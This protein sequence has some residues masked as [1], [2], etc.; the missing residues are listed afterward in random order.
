[1]AV[2]IARLFWSSGEFAGHSRKRLNAYN[3]WMILFV[4]I[5]SLC[6][7]YTANVIS[8]TLGEHLENLCSK[9]ATILTLVAAQPT[10]ITYFDLDTR[11]DATALISATNGI[12][13]TGGFLG[14]LTLPLFSD[15]FGRKGGLAIVSSCAPIR[16]FIIDMNSRVPSSASSQVPSW[17]AVLI[18]ECSSH[19]VSSQ[20]P[21]HS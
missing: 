19:S 11:A 2:G 1:M 15:K 13:Q 7:G 6:Y 4:S 17:L 21:V 16:K 18:S 20:V 5:G 3:A 12:F 8:A 14:T 9:I 10:F